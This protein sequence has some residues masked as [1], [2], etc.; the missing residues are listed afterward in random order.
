MYVTKPNLLE[1]HF[2]HFAGKLADAPGAAHLAELAQTAKAI[3][4]PVLASLTAKMA[5]L[6]PRAVNWTLATLAEEIADGCVHYGDATAFARALDRDLDWPE[7]LELAS[8]EVERKERD[9]AGLLGVLTIPDRRP[10]GHVEIHAPGVLNRTGWSVCN[11]IKFLEG[12]CPILKA[13]SS[14]GPP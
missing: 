5:R 14:E 3:P 2:L 9:A 6:N 11:E 1:Q 12:G 8:A 10:G 13:F 4:A 7:L